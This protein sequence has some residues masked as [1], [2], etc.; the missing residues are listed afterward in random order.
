[1]GTHSTH[2]EN[3]KNSI[4]FQPPTRDLSLPIVR[5]KVFNQFV[6]AGQFVNL[7]LYFLNTPVTKNMVGGR[8]QSIHRSINSRLQPVY[9]ITHRLAELVCPLPIRSPPKHI[10]DITAEYPEVN[11]ILFVGQ[12]VLTGLSLGYLIHEGG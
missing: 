10:T 12:L 5:S 6:L 11:A 2:V 1:M 3:L 4:Q 8:F 9:R 7:P